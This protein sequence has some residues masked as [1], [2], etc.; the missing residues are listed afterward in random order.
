MNNQSVMIPSFTNL[1]KISLNESDVDSISVLI[2]LVSFFS[3]RLIR[4]I[5]ISNS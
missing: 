2:D 4:L 3:E 1:R 5:Q